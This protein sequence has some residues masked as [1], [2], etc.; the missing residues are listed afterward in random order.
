MGC[1]VREVVCVCDMR[2]VLCVCSVREVMCD[3]TEI[4]YV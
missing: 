1:D 2:E 3:V 4:V